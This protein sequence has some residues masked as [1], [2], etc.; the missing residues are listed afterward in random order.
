MINSKNIL[1][2]K[3]YI[4]YRNLQGI[5]IIC[6]ALTFVESGETILNHPSKIE[7]IIEI[8]DD[9]AWKELGP[10]YSVKEKVY[11][12]K[13]IYIVEGDYK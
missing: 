2:S 3:S 8:T 4:A 12:N 1:F 13:E 9:N 6:I 7:Y 11:E 10:Y 5:F